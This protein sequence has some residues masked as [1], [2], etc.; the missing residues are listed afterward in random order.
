M[1]YPLALFLNVFFGELQF[2]PIEHNSLNDSIRKYSEID[3]EKALDFGFELLDAVDLNKVTRNLVGTYGLMGQV[4]ASK[5]YYNEALYYYSEALRVYKLIPKSDLV[6]PKPKS[7]PWLLLNIGNLYYATGDVENAKVKVLES[8]ENFLLF[9]NERNREIGLCTVYGNLGLFA[10]RQGDYKLAEEFFLKSLSKTEKLKNAEGV[11]YCYVQLVSLF[12]NNKSQFYKSNEYFD[13]A[14]LLF[15]NINKA[16]R[17]DENSLIQK[18]YG[19]LLLQY[20][21]YYR[22][23]KEFDTALNY[24]NEAKKLL[25]DFP[26]EIHSVNS[27]ISQFYL[28]L[29]DLNNAE[30]SA[31]ENLN[32]KSL[33]RFFK[34]VNFEVLESVYRQRNNL[35]KLIIIKD[36]LIDIGS[37]RVSAN[38]KAFF[39]NIETQIL[40]SNKQSELNQNK[41]RYNRYLFMLIIGLIILFFSLLYIRVN[42]NYQKERNIRL[43]VEK[44]VSK[45]K[46]EKK[47]L[48][49]VSKTNFIAQ[50]NNYLNILKLS[51]LKLKDKNKD[52]KKVSF[53][54]EKEINRIIGSEKIFENFESQFTEVYPE[55][56]KYLVLKYGKLSQTDLRLCAYI[57]MNQS[58]NEISQI[59][60]VA[61]RTVETQRYRLGK[62]LKLSD[63]ES[64]NSAII[65]I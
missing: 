60:G 38:S 59:T 4:L 2:T 30:K 44:D 8:K 12:L 19:Y 33:N 42:Y 45:T 58:T 49:L 21:E 63:S 52:S 18:Y 15:N 41:I 16:P 14:K 47:Q 43:E 29:K 32:D 1:F 5:S 3:P 28:S 57:K 46:L 65:S 64:L 9:I 35:K 40:L 36:S 61:I 22:S 27:Q 39:S 34:K 11:M 26:D 17:I 20:G 56:F 6:E 55:F 24:L 23:K 31:I 7:P 53:E 25:A 62:K 51:V 54:I 50:R 48:E 13:K 37:V 10:Q